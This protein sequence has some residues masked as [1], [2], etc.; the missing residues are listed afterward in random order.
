M[1]NATVIPMKVSF[2]F[3]LCFIFVFVFRFHETGQV[4]GS[5]WNLRSMNVQLREMHNDL[6]VW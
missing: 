2:R 6:G 4:W 1:L 3:I 5:S